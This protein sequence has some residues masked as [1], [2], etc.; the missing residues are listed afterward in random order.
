MKTI[1]ALRHL[2]TEIFKTSPRRTILSVVLTGA[3]SAT[4]GISLLLLMPL[5]A[6]VGIE[7]PTSMPSVER[8]FIS[9]SEGLGFSPNLLSALLLF[10]GVAGVRALLSRFQSSVTASVREDLTLGLRLRLY[11]AIAGA[12]WKFLVTRRQSEF[13]HVL[14]GEIRAIGVAAQQIIDLSVLVAISTVYV[15]LAFHFSPVM[16]FIVLS[17]SAVLAW[18]VRKSLRQ[19]RAVGSRAATARGNLHT[20]IT[21]H[22]SSIKTAKSYGATEQHANDFRLLSSVLREVNLEVTEGKTNLQQRLEFG[23]TLLLALIVYVSLEYF[24]VSPAQLL[25]LLFI[26]ARLMPRLVNVYRQIQSLASVL[27]NLDNLLELEQECAAAAEPVAEMNVAVDFQQHVRFENVSF[28]YLRRTEKPA[29]ESINLEIGAGLTTAIV[30]SSGAGKSTLADLLIGLL[31]PTTGNIL[32]DGKALG[33]ERL[34]AWRQQISYVPQETF[35]FHDTVRANLT[36]ARP[37]ATDAELIEALRLSAAY[38]FVTVLPQGLDTVLGERGVLVSGGERQRLSL[39]RALLRQPGILVLDEATSSLDSENE[40]RIQQAIESL[41]QKMTIVVITHRLSTIRHADQIHVLE[42]GRV[43][44]SGSWDHLL[45]AGG[46]FRELCRAQGI[47]ELAG[48][49]RSLAPTQ[50]PIEDHI[51]PVVLTS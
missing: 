11:R 40:L 15:A 4:E 49:P 13:V 47:D 38:D 34:N 25:V 20:A 32:I 10:V 21:E 14:D 3:L 50:F 29:L 23:S 45:R 17:C 24:T 9:I 19:A 36:W 37:G 31:S 5:L 12:E 7:E 18:I 41:H 48:N 51:E 16:S 1:I 22:I 33:A 39:A 30:G 8:W 2:A 46:R 35:L 26:F 27:P 43:V 28:A 6:M 44:E 42:N